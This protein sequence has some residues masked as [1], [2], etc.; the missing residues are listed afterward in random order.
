MHSK[1]PP[2]VPS[3]RFGFG[4]K[5]LRA[6]LRASFVLFSLT[7]PSCELARARRA[8]REVIHDARASTSEVPRFA[9]RESTE[10]DDE[11]DGR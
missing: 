10:F 5:R 9:K 1:I 7:F 11:S 6:M 4:A 3:F 8:P 2:R